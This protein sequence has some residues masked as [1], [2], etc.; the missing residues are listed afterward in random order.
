MKV[1]I[2]TN[3]DAHESAEFMAKPAKKTHGR[4]SE[5]GSWTRHHER[6]GN[7]PLLQARSFGFVR[8]TS[9]PVPNSLTHIVSLLFLGASA[10]SREPQ[11]GHIQFDSV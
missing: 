6:M 7:S 1:Q 8:D 11:W 5:A 10:P 9:W 4:F 2:N 3:V